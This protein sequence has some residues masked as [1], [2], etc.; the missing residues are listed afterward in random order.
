M[1]SADGEEVECAGRGKGAFG[2]FGQQGRPPEHRRREQGA[3]IRV[4]PRQ[5]PQPLLEVVLTLLAP[6]CEG[7]GRLQ[8]TQIFTTS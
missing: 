6:N 8:Y 2:F 5:R 3:T 1:Q 4:I 7:R